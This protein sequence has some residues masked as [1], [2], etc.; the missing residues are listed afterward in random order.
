MF[1]APNSVGPLK[2][3]YDSPA[4][5]G[6]SSI[7]PT[8]VLSNRSPTCRTPIFARPLNSAK[9]TTP[10][11]ALIHWNPM[12]L[13][14]PV[15]E[16]EIRLRPSSTSGAKHSHACEVINLSPRNLFD[17]FKENNVPNLLPVDLPPAPNNEVNQ[18]PRPVLESAQRVSEAGASFLSPPKKRK[19]PDNEVMYSPTSGA[20]LHSPSTVLV[21]SSGSDSETTP[22]EREAR[23]VRQREMRKNMRI[24][25][26]KLPFDSKVPDYDSISR[27]VE[28]ISRVLEPRFSTRTSVPSATALTSFK[29]PL[30]NVKKNSSSNPPNRKPWFILEFAKDVK[31]VSE[32]FLAPQNK[33][34]TIEGLNEAICWEDEQEAFRRKD[35]MEALRWEHEQEAF[36][37]EDE[38][39]ALRWEQEQEAI[40]WE[41]EVLRWKH[42]QEVHH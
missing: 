41:Q 23:R 5:S 3:R 16:G 17:S 26:I 39:Q 31:Q 38:M 15:F 9:K 8:L 28:T 19:Y 37:R 25:P 27:E 18:E 11:S 6:A 14:P 21:F 35:E 10:Q 36:R 24:K 13:D 22:N 20:T 40:R 30:R 2:S 34:E 12:L 29:L 1:V 42:E 4:A 7:A 33:Q 32:P